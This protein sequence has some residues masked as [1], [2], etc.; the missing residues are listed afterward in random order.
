[1]EFQH[2]FSCLTNLTFL[3]LIIFLS[4]YFFFPRNVCNINQP[5]LT[6]IND[7]DILI[8]KI[9]HFRKKF[10]SSI[11]NQWDPKIKCYEGIKESDILCLLK[12]IHKIHRNIIKIVN[13]DE[14]YTIVEE[15][16]IEYSEL[17][18]YENS[19]KSIHA[20]LKWIISMSC[21]LDKLSTFCIKSV[22][23]LLK[24]KKIIT[25]I[26]NIEENHEYNNI[27]KLILPENIE[28]NWR[29]SPSSQSTATSSSDR[30]T[31]LS[32]Y[33]SN[34]SD[35]LLDNKSDVL[36]DESDVLL[37]NKSEIEKSDIPLDNETGIERFNVQLDHKSD[38]LLDKKNDIIFDDHIANVPTLIDTPIDDPVSTAKSFGIDFQ[39]HFPG[40]AFQAFQNRYNGNDIKYLL[41]KADLMLGPIQM[42]N[43]DQINIMTLI[44]ANHMCNNASYQGVLRNFKTVSNHGTCTY[45]QAYLTDDSKKHYLGLLHTANGCYV[46]VEKLLKHDKFHGNEF[47]KIRININNLRCSTWLGHL[48]GRKGFNLKYIDL[49]IGYKNNNKYILSAY[50][51]PVQPMP[52]FV[53]KM[54]CGK[55]HDKS[56]NYGGSDTIAVSTFMACVVSG[57]MINGFENV[58]KNCFNYW[59][60]VKNASNVEWRLEQE[61]SD[62][63]RPSNLIKMW[64]TQICS[65]V[66]HPANSP[67][68]TPLEKSSLA[69][70]LCQNLIKV[71]TF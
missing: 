12:C 14:L 27:T 18:N 26:D 61:Y 39:L 71:E 25:S 44:V 59:H 54:S 33:P 2:L 30:I 48:I 22:S 63:L 70:K 69:D 6:H 51:H 31:P 64:A 55:V 50:S 37:D 7:I 11:K 8:N 24:S 35:V 19:F 67:K 10:N 36:L 17:K 29:N 5:I 38:V 40:E 49:I 41:Q 53:I 57:Q 4:Y 60:T 3:I 21:W 42:K 45:G 1:M 32:L 9:Y 66:N 52:E 15:I 62:Y 28:K 23:C 34:K 47:W 16:V 58:Y 68:F 56:D 20:R 46:E 65:V 13:S 43:M